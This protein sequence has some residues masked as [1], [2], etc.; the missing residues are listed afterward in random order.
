[1]RALTVLLVGIQ[2]ILLLSKLVKIAVVF[3]FRIIRNFIGICI[4]EI[5]YLRIKK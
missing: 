1:M 3:P 5:Q 4:R 2:M